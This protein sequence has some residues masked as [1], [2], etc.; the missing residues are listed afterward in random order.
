MG[1]RFEKLL[2]AA[3][4]NAYPEMIEDL[5]RHLK[6]SADSLRRLGVGF[7]PVVTFKNGDNYAGWWAFPMRDA[8]GAVIGLALRNQKDAKVVYPGSKPGLFYEV[9]PSYEGGRH[10]YTPGPHNWIRTMEAGLVCPICGKPDGCALSR[11]NPADPN[12]VL[13][14]RVKEGSVKALLLGWLHIRKDGGRMGTASL[15][16]ESGHPTLIVEGASDTAAAM[17]LGLVAIGKPSALVGLDM[18][19]ELV[20]GREVLVLGEND[21]QWKNGKEL[22]PGKDGMVATFQTL[23]RV[24]NKIKMA[25]PPVGVKDL[26]AWAGLTKESLLEYVETAGQVEASDEYLA[27]TRANTYASS[28][29]KKV[30]GM[31]SRVVLRRWESDWYRFQE[32]KYVKQSEEEMTAPMYPWAEAHRVPLEGK[33]SGF[34]IVPLTSSTTRNIREAIVSQTLITEKVIP[35][36]IN[37]V[38]GADPK[39]LV[40]FNNGILTLTDWL[41]VDGSANSLA[42]LTPDLFTISAIPI[43]FDPTAVCLKWEQFLVS[44]LGDDPAKILLLQEWFGY[45]LSGD[46]SLHKLMFLKGLPGAG[47]S[48]VHFVLEQLVGR[49]QSVSPKLE[50]LDNDF[51][52]QPMYGKMLC[53]IPDCKTPKEFKSMTGLQNLLTI[54]GDDSQSIRRKN[55]TNLPNQPLTCRVSIAANNFLGIP[56]HDLATIRRLNIIVFDRV[57][58]IPD[59]SLHQKLA[60]ELPGI[61]NWALQ[62]LRRLREQGKFTV[63]P[64]SAAAEKEWRLDVSPTAAFLE[65][66]TEPGEVC[67]KDQLYDCYRG[68]E[69]ANHSESTNR[70]RFFSRLASNAPGLVIEGDKIRGLA[71]KREA[72]RKYLGDPN[73]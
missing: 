8:S 70:G 57:P 24:T 14:L 34:E 25:L 59:T 54:T 71:I 39:D 29:L 51:A 72:R 19:A 16:P 42:P 23:S 35:V 40:V 32:S 9:N 47:K 58:L 37:G 30:H 65:E 15:L 50:D 41:S 7:M 28:F 62:G 20:R 38:E 56:D 5:A 44:A 4:G 43:S 22:W 27:D 11:E 68:W 1:E 63:P 66:C 26:R 73:A 17:D 10:A 61:V 3:Q 48:T 46:R 31:G 55:L 12:A 64:S 6:V 45:I 53:I 49:D 36:W 69:K 67:G 33:D 2:A 21:R 60:A 18:V 52:L 13:C